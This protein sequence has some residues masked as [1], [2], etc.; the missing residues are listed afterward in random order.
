MTVLSNSENLS[1][2][3][4]HLVLSTR[5]TVEQMLRSLLSLVV[6]RATNLLMQA[7]PDMECLPPA[8]QERSSLVPVPSR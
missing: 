8:S 2:D 7:T 6:G 3:I 4:Q 5:Q 1:P